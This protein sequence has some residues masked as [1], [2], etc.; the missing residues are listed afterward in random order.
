MS[1]IERLS[2]QETIERAFATKRANL[3]EDH[4]IGEKPALIWQSSSSEP[5]SADVTSDSLKNAI[6]DGA[7][8]IGDNGW[9]NNFHSYGCAPALVFD[10]LASSTGSEHQWV[11][12]VHT[13]GHFIAACWAFPEYSDHGLSGQGIADFYTDAFRDFGYVAQRVYEALS[14]TGYLLCQ[15]DREV[16][17]NCLE[18]YRERP[19]APIGGT[20]HIQTSFFEFASRMGISYGLRSHI[21]IRAS[22]LRL[23]FAQMRLRYKRLNLEVPKLLSVSFEDG[24]AGGDYKGSDTLDLRV[25]TEIAELFGPGEWTS[26]EL[27]AVGYGGLKG[28]LANFYAGHSYKK[29]LP[30]KTL[31]KLT[32]YESHM[33]N[34]KASLRTALDKLMSEETPECSRIEKYYFSE[35][36]KDLLVI[37][38][39]WS[40]NTAR[41]E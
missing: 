41:D 7:E 24:E 23:S 4:I 29:W 2:H 28:W 5:F 13:D 39:A 37:R 34:F 10:G 18:Y 26:V 25:T 12:E 21:A 36:E 35:D 33:R 15:F 1:L 30:I 22:L 14:Y 27:A 16:Y 40:S 9:W 3:V 8:A 32:G 6:R 19:L 20:Q 17:A 38:T 11:T 31:Y